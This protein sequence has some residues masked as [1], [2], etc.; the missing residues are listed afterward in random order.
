MIKKCFSNKAFHP[1]PPSLNYKTSQPR[2]TSVKFVVLMCWNVWILLQDT[3]Y[4]YMPHADLLQLKIYLISSAQD[5]IFHG[6]ESTE[7]V[8]YSSW[9]GNG[10]RKEGKGWF[11][12]W[13]VDKG[14]SKACKIS[15]GFLYD[16]LFLFTRRRP[17]TW[18][19]C[20]E[21]MLEQRESSR[22]TGWI[23]CSTWLRLGS[24]KW[25]WL[26]S[27]LCRECALATKLGLV[28]LKDEMGGKIQNYNRGW[29][30]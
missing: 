24:Q 4:M 10:Q 16:L 18:L 29:S 6:F 20:R 9:W 25:S 15:L 5:N 12:Q 26:R 23:C 13:F 21:K 14:T 17:T 11:F 27:E 30:N 8:W 7:H 28:K 3:F 2:N 22:T 19:C 1:N